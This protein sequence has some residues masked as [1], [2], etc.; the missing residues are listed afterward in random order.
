MTRTTLLAALALSALLITACQSPLSDD[1]EHLLLQRTVDE[2]V[3]RET[4]ELPGVD[5]RLNTAQTPSDVESELADRRQELDE[6]S[7]DPPTDDGLI[8]DPLDLGPDLTGSDQDSTAIS[9]EA[10]VRTSVKNNLT[11]QISRIQPAV[12]EAD[13]VAA[14]AV[15]DSIF[16]ADTAFTKVD[17]P[18]TVPILNGIPLGTPFNAA[19]SY[20]FETGVRRTLTSGGTVEVSTDLTRSENQTPGIDLSPD[21]AYTAAIRLGVSQPLLRGFGSEVNTSA[22]RLSQNAERRSIQDL[23]SDLMQIVAESEAAYWDLALAWHTLNIQGWLVDV[24]EEV[25]VVLERRRDFDTTQAQYSDAV[26][27]V[28]QRK[29]DVIRARRSVREA[30][31]RLKVLLNDPEVTV[32]SED[33]FV[34]LDE[35]VSTPISYSLRDAIVTAITS[36]PEVQQ[37]ILDI[38]DA[39]IREVLADNNRLPLLLASAEIAYFGLDDDAGNSYDTLGDGDFIDYFVGLTLEIPIGNREAEAGF[40]A[41]RLQRSQAVI[42]YRRTVQNVIFEV[43]RALRSVLTNYELIAAT[44]SNRVAQAEN[45]RALLAEEETLASLTPEFL[46]LKFQRQDRLAIARFDEIEALVLFDQAVAEL[47]RA[48]GIGLDMNQIELEIVDEDFSAAQDL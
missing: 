11:I 34:P 38:D 18:T 28:E 14:E 35:M 21:P 45:L 48:M 5:E 25:R 47:Y 4:G 29:A 44:R 22:I 15:F 39:E 10:A 32:G 26:A 2:A 33:V 31:D 37:S 9:L 13:V 17:Q 6:L 40:R 27:R 43:K 1:E 41:A 3:D 36:R 42:A 24:G 7:P 23:R 19:R 16:F 30:S 8:A 20:R 46:D 12:N